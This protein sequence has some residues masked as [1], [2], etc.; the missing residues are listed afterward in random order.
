MTE[1]SLFSRSLIR[2]FSLDTSSDLAPPRHVGTVNDY[3]NTFIA[4]TLHV[5]IT[6]EQHQ[7]SLFVTGL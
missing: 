2:N 5:G 4:Y 3:I 7:V 1:W 6:S